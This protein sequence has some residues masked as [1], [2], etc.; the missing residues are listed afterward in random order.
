MPVDLGL[1]LRQRLEA[2]WIERNHELPGIGDLARIG[3]EIDAIA[4][5]QR[6]VERAGEQAEHQRKAGALV[7]AHRQQ[8]RLAAF[9]RIGDCGAGFRIDHPV[10]L[11]A[12]G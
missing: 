4:T 3:V 11:A 9:L 8:Q 5:E 12:A 10:G 6:A 2:R 1:E 7:A